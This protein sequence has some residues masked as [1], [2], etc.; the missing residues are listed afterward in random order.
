MRP[1]IDARALFL[2]YFAD[3]LAVDGVGPGNGTMEVTL[4]YETPEV[5]AEAVRRRP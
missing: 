5:A 3:A 4:F 1:R 2:G